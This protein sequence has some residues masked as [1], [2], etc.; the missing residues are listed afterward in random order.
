[1]NTAAPMLR[2][3][4]CHLVCSSVALITRLRRLH[5]GLAGIVTCVGLGARLQI[6]ASL[7]RKFC[8]SAKL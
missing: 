2:R 8:R 4:R 6:L 3:W 7:R 1:M 5:G